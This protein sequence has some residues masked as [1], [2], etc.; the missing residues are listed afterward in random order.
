MIQA[1]DL[2]VGN[3]FNRKHGKGWTWTVIDEGII[4][5]VFSESLEYALDDF[6]PIP[7]T[8]EILERCGFS[9]DGFYQYGIDASSSLSTSKRR[10]YFGGDYLY[11]EEED[12]NLNRDLITIWNKD[13]MKVFYL[14][15]LQNLYFTLTG[16][17][18]NYNPH[19]K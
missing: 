16:K 17:E 4:R 10:L 8:P 13:L 15:Q 7:L 3:I 19:G 11:L 12:K 18:L 1:R 5:S 9:Q 14:H 2:I 6:E